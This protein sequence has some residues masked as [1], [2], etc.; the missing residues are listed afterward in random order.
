MP[1]TVNMVIAGLI[2]VAAALG[3]A[4]VKVGEL[5]GLGRPA[6]RGSLRAPHGIVVRT[7]GLY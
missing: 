6:P 1:V 7:R 2:V 5:A 4:F 3:L